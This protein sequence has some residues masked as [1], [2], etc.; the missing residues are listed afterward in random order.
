VLPFKLTPRTAAF[1]AIGMLPIGNSTC[2]A[3][4][5]LSAGSCR[6]TVTTH[7]GAAL[8]TIGCDAVVTDAA[9][10]CGKRMAQLPVLWR[11][12]LIKPNLVGFPVHWKRMRLWW[13]MVALDIA[14]PP[15]YMPP[16]CH[17]SSRCAF[18]TCA[19]SMTDG[20]EAIYAAP[21]H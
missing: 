10:W 17:W 2:L 9:P 4:R 13:A 15:A 7:S 1:T 21:R 6:K 11:C 3:Q 18:T 20:I 16:A 5:A 19:R 12:L 14:L 8:F